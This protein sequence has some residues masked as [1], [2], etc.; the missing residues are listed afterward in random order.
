[1]NKQTKKQIMREYE[2][3]TGWL[4]AFSLALLPST[5]KFLVK[6]TGF[7]SNVCRLDELDLF[8]PLPKNEH[9]LSVQYD[10]SGAGKVWP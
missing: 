9:T 3:Q 8:L 1:M 4:C 5:E 6:K 10:I 7:R 2:P